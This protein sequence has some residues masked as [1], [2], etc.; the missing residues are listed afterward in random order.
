MSTW[1]EHVIWWQVYPLGLVKAESAPVDTVQHRLPELTGWLDYLVELGANGLALNP[2]FASSTHGYDTTDY[3]SVDKRLGDEADLVTLFAA[4]HDRGIKVLLDGVFNHVGRQ[5]PAFQAVLERG[6]EAETANWFRVDWPED[7][8]P[9]DD[10]PAWVFEGHESLVSLNHHEPAVVEMVA[11]V[12][13]YWLDRGADGWR[14]D[15]AYAVDSE[16]WRRVLPQVREKHPE[17]WIVGEVIHGDY[18]QLISDTGMD[19]LTQ[20]ELWQGIW[21]SISQTNFF[22]LEHSL[23]R[24]NTF[25]ESFTP[26]TFVGNHDVSRIANQVGDKRHLEHALVVLFTVG[27][28]P[29]IYYG[30]EQGYRGVKQERAGG[31]DEVRPVYPDSPNKFSEL[32]RPIHDLHQRLISLRRQSHLTRARTEVLQVSNEGLVYRTS[33]AENSLIVGLNIGDEAAEVSL[34]AGPFTIEPHGWTIRR[35]DLAEA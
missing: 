30:D 6:P 9:G 29:S 23:G 24:H 2:V 3:F 20:Y 16:F 5:H 27:G 21:H 13:S 18:P 31:D 28:V 4:C 14:L 35:S 17:V 10:V 34:E 26:L 11:E 25:L 33:T 22:E 19:S 7:W 12:M 1:S 8:Q 32:G 15:A